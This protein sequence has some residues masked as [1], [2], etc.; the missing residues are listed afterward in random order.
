MIKRIVENRPVFDA[1]ET[2][3]ISW[4]VD[5]STRVDFG[6][7]ISSFFSSKPMNPHS[8]EFSAKASAS[9]IGMIAQ[10][11][12]LGEMGHAICSSLRE[13]VHVR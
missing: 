7:L 3:K 12:C 10:P 13:Q 9:V 6:R 5:A 2:R 1:L 11:V 4:S 8:A